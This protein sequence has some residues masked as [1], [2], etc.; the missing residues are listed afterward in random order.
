MKIYYQVNDA[1][2]QQVVGNFTKKE[3]AT[4]LLND[5]CEITNTLPKQRF[6]ISVHYV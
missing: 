2:T 3:Y 6:W 4:D 5:L 1:S